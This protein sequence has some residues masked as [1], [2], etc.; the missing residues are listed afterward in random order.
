MFGQLAH[1]HATKPSNLSPR[2]S[3]EGLLE[4]L[5][6]RDELTLKRRDQEP[7]WSLLTRNLC[8]DAK[9]EARLVME[10]GCVWFLPFIHLESAVN[11]LVF[12]HWRI[13]PLGHEFQRNDDVH[14][15]R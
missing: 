14:G 3:A 9:A 2:A 13:P 7:D 6:A 12:Q 1:N 8:L 4:A 10:L 15:R 11:L 5:R